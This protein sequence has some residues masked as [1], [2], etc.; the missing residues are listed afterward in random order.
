MK[1]VADQDIFAVERIFGGFGELVLLPGRGI[2]RQDLVG[3][4]ALLVRSVRSVDRSLLLDTGVGF[5]GAATSGLDHIDSEWLGANGV[6]LAHCRGANAWAVVEYCLGAIANLRLAG[7]I[8][9]QRPSIGVVG[10]GAIGG[11]LARRMRELGHE[12]VVCDPPLAELGRAW[13][14]FAWRPLPDAL[15][16]DIVSLHVPLTTGGRHPSRHLLD[17]AA[18]ARLRPGA[19]LINASRGGVVDEAALLARLRNGPDLHCVVDVW[20]NEPEVDAELAARAALATPHIAGYSEQAKWGATAM[21]ARQFAEHFGLARVRFEDAAPGAEPG[22]K[23]SAKTSMKT[24]ANL[25]IPGE[26]GRDRL[27]HWRIVDRCLGLASLSGRFRRWVLERRADPRPC[28]PAEA[29]DRLRQPLL[30]RQEF[31]AMKLTGAQVLSR[32][33]QRWL[34]RLGF[35]LRASR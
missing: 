24:N 22:T 5:V 26:W 19:V 18:L 33:Q 30:G 7:R 13:R 6:A 17:A 27:A 9:T 35:A 21:L 16:C 23:A 20:Q 11:R 32:P 14:E 10:A 12:V 34:R 15:D 3:A 2:G 4:D 25:A 31:T 28:P 8:E 29:F 1:I